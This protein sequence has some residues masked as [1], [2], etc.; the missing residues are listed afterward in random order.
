MEDLFEGVVDAACGIVE[1]CERPLCVI[2]V[3]GLVVAAILI[4]MYFCK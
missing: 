1:A 4:A 2:L 3:V